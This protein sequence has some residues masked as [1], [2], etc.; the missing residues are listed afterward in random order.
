VLCVGFDVGPFERL[1]AFAVLCVGFD[2]GPFLGFS[3]FAAL[4]VG[5][6]VGSFLGFPAFPPFGVGLDLGLLPGPA[7]SAQVGHMK[8]S[9]ELPRG[10]LRC[11]GPHACAPQS[12]HLK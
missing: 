7:L 12:H 4:G 2:V 8:S 9:P 5:L 10:R 6:E 1:P 11:A 3:A